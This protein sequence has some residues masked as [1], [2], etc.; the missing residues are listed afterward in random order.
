MKTHRRGNRGRSSAPANTPISHVCATA[1]GQS[2]A[3]A[4]GRLGPINNATDLL[5]NAAANDIPAFVAA[6][7]LIHLL[8]GWK[9]VSAAFNAYLTNSRSAG[10][11]FAYYAELRAALSLFA[12][13]GIRVNQFD[14][15]YL[16]SG[17]TKYQIVGDTKT[18]SITWKIWQEWIKRLDA[19]E[20]LTKHVRLITGVTLGDF[21][22]AGN[23]LSFALQN[24][25][26]DL[27]SLARDHKARN[28][29]SY[30]PAI[31]MP[32][33][34]M[35]DPDAA[36]IKRIWT[37]LLPTEHGVGFDTSFINFLV[38]KT[39]LAKHQVDQSKTSSEHMSAMIK[40]ASTQTGVEES[41]IRSLLVDSQP[42]IG[43]FEKAAERSEHVENVL[44]RALFL[45]R[46]ATLSVAKSMAIGAP[47]PVANWLKNWLAT[48]G[49]YEE[50]DVDPR[51]LSE[52]Y[53]VA[54]EEYYQASSS[55]PH[56]LWSPHEQNLS[57]TAQLARPDAFVAWAIE[58]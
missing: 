1:S 2:V 36:L 13:S 39:S 37:L 38:S 25:G 55:L 30:E 56:C 31:S 42:D 8:D 21:A 49:L 4:F 26:Y 54:S 7:Q 6:E 47:D 17:G 43:L 33:R 51:D 23:V 19:I 53:R 28:T 40:A 46:M 5:Y 41:V 9:Y 27:F 35:E 11:H 57:A 29:A 44:C 48:G 50:R 10:T 15:Y 58:L 24:W 52:D 32:L 12:G 18:H 22:D 20:L 34:G 14:S 45:L 3:T 16:D